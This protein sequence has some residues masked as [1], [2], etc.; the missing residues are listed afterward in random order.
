LNFWTYV[1]NRGVAQAA[2]K[3]VDLMTLGKDEF[4][5]TDDETVLRTAMDELLDKNFHDAVAARASRVTKL[6]SRTRRPKRALGSSPKHHWTDK[7]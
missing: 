6:C 1:D 5:I 3:A 4:F 7:A 2:A